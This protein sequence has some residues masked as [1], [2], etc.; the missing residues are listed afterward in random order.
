MG[1]IGC[2]DND[3]VGDGFHAAMAFC[4]PI[5]VEELGNG[6]PV[7]GAQGLQHLLITAPT[8]S[9]DPQPHLRMLF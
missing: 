3:Q 4:Q 2:P 7:S 9:R 1:P 5:L 6:E 8:V